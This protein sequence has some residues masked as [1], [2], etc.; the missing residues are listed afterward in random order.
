M[1][2][3][4]HLLTP[5]EKA[6]L[7]ASLNKDAEGEKHFTGVLGNRNSIMLPKPVARRVLA[8]VKGVAAGV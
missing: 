3:P 8:A 7:I 6:A 5:E 4:L 1:L 2:K